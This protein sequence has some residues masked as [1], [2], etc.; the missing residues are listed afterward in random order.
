MKK[1]C[2]LVDQ[3][4]QHGGIEKLVA[5]KANYWVSEFG[6]ELTILSSEQADKPI[7]YKLHKKVKLEDLNINYKRG[8][9]YFSLK[10]LFLFI[11]NVWLIQKYIW[12]NKPDFVLV[13]SHIP[14]TYIIPFLVKGKT[15]IIK[16]FHF[17]KYHYD[18]NKL[19]YRI[20]RWIESLY[21]HLIVLNPDEGK[22]YPQNKVRIIPNSLTLSKVDTLIPIE[23]KKDIATAVLRFAPVKRIESMIA[24]WSR[25]NDK[26]FTVPLHIY[27]DYKNLYGQ[28][29]TNLI[30]EKNL[31]HLIHLKGKTDQVA[32]V[33]NTTKILIVTSAQEC[34]PLNVLESFQMGV[35]VIAFDVP[36]GLRNIITH[37]ENGYLIADNDLKTYVES[38][39]AFFKNKETQVVLSKMAL[40]SSKKYQVPIIMETWKKTIFEA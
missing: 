9:S 15:Q 35:P 38:L 11:K 36:T 1:I 34:F 31:E 4:Y 23:N 6:Y 17:T 12:K 28:E 13:A 20:F 40:E 30:K 5:L 33:L 25:L 22:F 8:K 3:L 21:D 14:I 2:I 18:F 32:K 37:R 39:I 19:K 16:E 10:N 7:V 26:G 27:G 24:I 29:I